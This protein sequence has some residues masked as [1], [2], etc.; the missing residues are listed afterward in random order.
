MGRSKSPR[1]KRSKSRSKSSRR[2]KLSQV[3]AKKLGGLAK[4]VRCRQSGHKWSSAQGKC[5]R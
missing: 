1:R 2:R 4:V 5:L 3:K